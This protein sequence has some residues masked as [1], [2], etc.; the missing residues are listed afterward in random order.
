MTEPLIM[1]RPFDGDAPTDIVGLTAM[2]DGTG[3]DTLLQ[4]E[5]SS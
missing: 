3:D 1:W 4:S 5:Q 2:Q